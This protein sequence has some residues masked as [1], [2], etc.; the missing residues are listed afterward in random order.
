MRK[1][2]QVFLYTSLI[3]TFILVFDCNDVWSQH[4]N[5]LIRQGNN[6]YEE[7]KFNEAEIKYRKALEKDTSY[8]ATKFNLG[9]AM[10]KQNNYKEAAEIFGKLALNS[11]LDRNSKAK[12][13][14]NLGNIALQTKQYDKSIMMYKESLKNN[15][16]D[17]DTKYNLSY[18]IKKLQQQQQQQKNQNQDKD[19]NKD[20]QQKEQEQKQQEKEKE[21][22]QQ[23]QQQQN[24]NKQD[25]ER[26]LNAINNKE[27]ETK[28]KV[29]KKEGQ[30]VRINVEKDW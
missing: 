1:S 13:F 20:K 29:D 23:Q 15:P 26:M 9:D 19:K 27:K 30:A 14:H 11:N 24:M 4:R 8:F 2:N 21:E 28:E 10:Y 22:Q 7:Q 16:K 17:M 18:A 3:L 25:A 5:K 6:L 12:V